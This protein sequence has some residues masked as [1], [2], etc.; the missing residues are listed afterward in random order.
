MHDLEEPVPSTVLQRSH[1]IAEYYRCRGET[2]ILPPCSTALLDVEHWF[3]E[4]F[5]SKT[6]I[7]KAKKDSHGNNIISTSHILKGINT[8]HLF[9]YE[10]EH[11][12][13]IQDTESTNEDY[14]NRCSE[15]GSLPLALLDHLHSLNY[16]IS[17]VVCLDH[18]IRF[19]TMGKIFR[20]L[21]LA[22][23]LK[24][25]GYIPLTE[26]DYQRAVSKLEFTLKF[27]DY[28]HFTT[29]I[30][31]CNHCSNYSMIVFFQCMAN[32]VV[33]YKDEFCNS[34]IFAEIISNDLKRHPRFKEGMMHENDINVSERRNSGKRYLIVNYS[35]QCYSNIVYSSCTKENHQINFH[36]KCVF[37]YSVIGRKIKNKT[38]ADL[39][40]TSPSINCEICHDC[41]VQVDTLSVSPFCRHIFC[42]KCI[43]TWQKSDNGNSG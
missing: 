10:S 21:V 26:T 39:V 16:V 1:D 28:S 12:Q 13:I 7:R 9:A 43:D 5:L 22:K 24:N 6:S 30:Q 27:Y 17:P 42:G 41:L 4:E 37:T 35:D 36:L 15:Y 23:Y 31:L 34:Y 38:K 29:K 18:I 3:N 25:S 33:S 2:T 19:E 32:N 40:A 11:A 8:T 20:A 14:R